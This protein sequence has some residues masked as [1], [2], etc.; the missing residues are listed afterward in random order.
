MV[1]FKSWQSYWRFHHSVKH[2][3]RYVRSPEVEDFL[4]AV[5]ESGRERVDLLKTGSYV[6]RAQL[7]YVSA[8]D[9]DPD[10]NVFEVPYSEDRMKPREG[11]A[12]EG[13]ANPKGIPYLYCAT[14]KETALAEVRPWIGSLISLGL[15]SIIRDLRLLDCTA[16]KKG[17]RGFFSEP[18][19]EVREEMVWTHINHAFAAPVGLSDDVA[20]YV[21]TQIIAE[22]FKSEGFDGIVY[23]S[24]LVEEENNIVIFDLKVAQLVNCRLF[25]LK[26]LQFEF[27]E[28]GT[29]YAT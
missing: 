27:N 11:R 6:W 22:L 15:F 20:D 23:A 4:S 19:P 25:R 12:H 28:E 21:P 9:H 26:G 18:A 3:A 5:R 14:S 7:G 2:D 17:F 16:R 13:R 10:G 1:E 29:G 8:T 24:S